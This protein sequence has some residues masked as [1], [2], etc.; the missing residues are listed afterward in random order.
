MKYKGLFFDFDYTLGD[1]T[2]AIVAGFVYGL[3]T[4]GYPLPT[5]KE[6]R[7][8]VGLVLRDGFT[9]LTGE[10]D[11]AKRDEFSDLYRL[12]SSPMQPKAAKLFPGAEELLRDMNGR[13]V[14]LAVVS[15]KPATV[16]RPVLEEKGILDCFDIVLGSDLVK[17]PKPDP[18]GILFAAQELGLEKA[19]ILYC[20]DTTIDAEAGMRAGVDFCPV[21][22]GTTPA[23]DFEGYPKVFLARNLP[24]LHTWLK[25]ER[26]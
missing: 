11:P 1:A 13:G 24:E 22:N 5:R 23:E 17:N 16:L 26:A 8:T 21:L 18:E 15:S 14:K 19:E 7:G 10:A 3:Y 25:E 4:M 20:G 2:E 9:K 12:C 6:I